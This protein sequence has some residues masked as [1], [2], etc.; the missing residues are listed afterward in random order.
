MNIP[1]RSAALAR[2]LASETDDL[3]KDFAAQVAA[4]AE[5][6]DRRSWS[7]NDFALLG[8]FVAMLGVCVAGWLLLA[9]QE[10]ASVQWLDLPARVVTSQ[11][12]LFVGVAGFVIVHLLSFRRRAMT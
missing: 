4:L 7:W 6:G 8:A 3:P 12:W 9:P 1:Q 10:P 5:S 11:P 2:A